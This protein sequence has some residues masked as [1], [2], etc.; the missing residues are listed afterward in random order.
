MAR[1]VGTPNK[2][3]H[4]LKNRI[5]DAYGKDYDIILMMADTCQKL[6]NS[7]P[8]TLADKDDFAQAAV[9]MANIDKLAAYLEPKQAAI[10]IEA[11]IKVRPKLVDLSGGNLTKEVGHILEHEQEAE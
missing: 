1:P 4:G 3:R 6:Y 7:L 11:D 9:A 10:K 8:A 5:K 2:P